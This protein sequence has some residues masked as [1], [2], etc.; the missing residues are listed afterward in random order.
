L[1]NGGRRACNGPPEEGGSTLVLGSQ[2]GI[3]VVKRVVL[4]CLVLGAPASA[5]MEFCIVEI[6]K[7]GYLP[8]GKAGQ[9]STAFG[10]LGEFGNGRLGVVRLERAAF[11]EPG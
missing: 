6:L 2:E 10:K 4:V 8:N 1:E 5:T 11:L 3:E 7:R 9:N